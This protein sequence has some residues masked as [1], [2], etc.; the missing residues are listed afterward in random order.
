MIEGVKLVD[1]V[2]HS[3]D[4]GDL[5]EVLHNYELPKLIEGCTLKMLNVGEIP[6]EPVYRF[7]Q[8]YI[9]HNRMPYVVRAFHKHEKLWDYFSIIQG[10]AVFCLVDDQSKISEASLWYERLVLTSRKPKLLVVPPGV[11]HGWMSL[12]PDTILLSIGSELYDRENPDEVRVPF[13][14]FN[15]LFGRNPWEIWYR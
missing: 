14:T 7:G 1:L 3:D 10:S 13:D 8:V 11:Y 12:E 15:G 4:R 9:V 5:F 2:V 6:A